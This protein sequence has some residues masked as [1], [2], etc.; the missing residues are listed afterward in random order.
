[1]ITVIAQIRIDI[2]HILTYILTGDIYIQRYVSRYQTQKL[3][4]TLM[5]IFGPKKKILVNI[6]FWRVFK[7]VVIFRS[8]K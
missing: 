3:F 8:M 5:N 4:L 2:Y 7:T 1:M 6:L